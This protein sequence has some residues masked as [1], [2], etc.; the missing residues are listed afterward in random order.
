MEGQDPGWGWY[1]A[2]PAPVNSD[3]ANII[4]NAAEVRTLPATGEDEVEKMAR[5][6]TQSSVAPADSDDANVI[7]NAAEVGSSQA[8][9]GRASTEVAQRTT[10]SPRAIQLGGNTVPP[11][12][13][14]RGMEGGMVGL[15][16]TFREWA[17]AAALIYDPN[18]SKAR[19]IKDTPREKWVIWLTWPGFNSTLNG[20][21]E[22]NELKAGMSFREY[23]QLVEDWH[24]F[25]GML[26]SR[27]FRGDVAQSTAILARPLLGIGLESIHS[28]F[29]LCAEICAVE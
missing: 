23:L 26:S 1:R 21:R 14:S 2:G 29:D 20:Y 7:S 19:D 13:W 5:G 12:W 16:Q 9:G 11:L 17:A 25:T 15:Q 18:I 27:L 4:P 28:C 24:V 6:E 22:S 8:A 3:D 10:Q